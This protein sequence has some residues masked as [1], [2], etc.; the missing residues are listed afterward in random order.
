MSQTIQVA[1]TDCGSFLEK[2]MGGSA[3]PL[4]VAAACG[5]YTETDHLIITQMIR[6]KNAKVLG[7]VLVF[8]R[9]NADGTS[10][11]DVFQ[12]KP[13][14][15]VA[16]R[17]KYETPK[18][19]SN[20][21]YFPP[22][23][24]CINAVRS[25][26]RFVVITEGV[27]KAISGSCDGVP[28]IGLSGVEN[29]SA[30]RKKDAE[31]QRVGVR[32]LCDDILSI[33]WKGRPVAIMFDTDSRVNPNVNRASCSLAEALE[34]NG[35]KVSILR[36][37]VE[38]DPERQEFRK[39]GID[40]W[41]IAK[42]A[43]SFRKFIDDKTQQPALN[44]ID[45]HRTEMRERRESIR[46]APGIFLDRSGTGSGKSHADI[47]EILF[48]KRSLTVVPRHEI[49]WEVLKKYQDAGID[50]AIYPEL[51][52]CE[53]TCKG[54]DCWRYQ[55]GSDACVAGC[56]IDYKTVDFAISLGFSA[57][58]TVCLACAAKSNCVYRM[59]LAAVEKAKHVIATNKRF[60]LSLGSVAD[61]AGFITVHE[62]ILDTLRP[63][64]EIPG[65]A[66]TIEAL[67]SIVAAV[68]EAARQWPTDDMNMRHL[69]WQMRESAR[70]F[71][72]VFRTDPNKVRCGRIDTKKLGAGTVQ[73]FNFALFNLLRNIM[74]KK[75]GDVLKLCFLAATG[76]LSECTVK[77][78][79][80]K[81]G[82]RFVSIVGVVKVSI[83]ENA[84]VILND[85][86]ANIETLRTATGLDIVDITP[87]APVKNQQRIIQVP[88]DIT[89]QTKSEKV[90][91][92]IRSIMLQYSDRNKIGII[93]HRKHL[94]HIR[95]NLTESE[96][97]RIAKTDYFRGL[98]SRGSNDW[99]RC[100][101]LI[102]AGTPRVPPG[103]I[104]TALV[105]SGQPEAIDRA[106]KSEKKNWRSDYWLGR[107]ETGKAVTV[108]TLG[109]YD[110]AWQSAHRSIVAEELQQCIGRARAI[111]DYGVPDTVV[112]STENLGYQLSAENPQILAEGFLRGAASVLA[113]FFRAK[114][115]VAHRK[116][117]GN[118]AQD[119]LNNIIKEN[120]RIIFP[121]LTTKKIV[122]SLENKAR[123]VQ[124]HLQNLSAL[125]FIEKVG[126]RS[127]WRLT[128]EHVHRFLSCGGG[129][130]LESSLKE[131]GLT[132]EEKENETP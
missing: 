102:V 7:N 129:A 33:N 45:Q 16:G 91:G 114:T 100:D 11:E 48:Y 87:T 29:W 95:K 52:T 31:G 109:Y 108:R 57:S 63:Y 39:F 12:V 60:S 56:C 30:P 79:E 2:E 27:K 76:N 10:C 43:G 64:I 18:G 115:V 94:L 22:L 51:S 62:S 5:I 49:G 40:D 61:S 117:G 105:Q 9:F 28:T 96:S 1:K 90:L 83:P 93:S 35:A 78:A 107:M 110:H 72:E 82:E 122:L 38:Y 67:E 128:S 71:L 88:S 124:L 74:P 53:K 130:A 66:E 111:C 26:G 6:W 85:A 42:G 77:V 98:A 118:Y 17:G 24:I 119:L 8:P 123:T 101:L 127:G 13:A 70:A 58:E 4:D 112:I 15:P 103:V 23:P 37:P 68:Q 92:L 54:E 3:I 55:Y 34:R 46:S 14:N 86:S 131:S 116:K 32:E 20:C 84:V 19:S 120:L 121:I 99:M 36:F 21:V 41:I 125:G 47:A 80:S 89:Q 132:N 113:L 126:E 97:V 81:T 73:G 106:L 65:K 69:A 104:G 44:S 59:R 75:S 50:A 25:P